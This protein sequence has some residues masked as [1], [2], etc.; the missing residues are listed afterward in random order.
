MSLTV[1]RVVTGHDESGAAVILTDAPPE[2]AVLVFQ[3]AGSADETA[4]AIRSE[5]NRAAS[6]SAVRAISRSLTAR[7]ATVTVPT[8]AGRS[9]AQ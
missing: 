8:V 7:P 9:P 2:R 1:R 6:C 3:V 4:K 5:L